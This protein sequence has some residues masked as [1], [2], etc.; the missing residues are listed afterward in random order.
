MLYE[1]ITIALYVLYEA[2][3]DR[4]NVKRD[5]IYRLVINGKIGGQEVIGSYTPSV[6][7]PTMAKDYPEIEACLRLNNVITSYSIHY[8]KLYDIIIYPL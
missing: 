7:G 6:M 3:Y 5:R 4:F 8:T 2:S 1:V